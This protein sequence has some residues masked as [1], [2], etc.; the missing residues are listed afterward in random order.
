MN[1]IDTSIL[2]GLVAIVCTLSNIAYQLSKIR[3]TL[4]KKQ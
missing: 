4:E 3:E 1:V 2:I